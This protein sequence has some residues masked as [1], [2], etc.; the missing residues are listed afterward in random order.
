MRGTSGFQVPSISQP[1]KPPQ[2]SPALQHY[3]TYQ[4]NAIPPNFPP[5]TSHYPGHRKQNPNG[6]DQEFLQDSSYSPSPPQIKTSTSGSF[7]FFLSRSIK[8]SNSCYVKEIC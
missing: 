8:L 1:H 5:P 2:F 4:T 7:Y 3:L 6:S